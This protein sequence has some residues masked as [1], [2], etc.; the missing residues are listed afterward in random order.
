MFPRLIVAVIVVGI[1][2]ITVFYLKS[3]K[4]ASPTNP[5]NQ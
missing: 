3:R 4:S 1:I 5:K 2:G